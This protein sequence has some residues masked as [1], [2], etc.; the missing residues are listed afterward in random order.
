[1]GPTRVQYQFKLLVTVWTTMNREKSQLL[2]SHQF[3]KRGELLKLPPA[4]CGSIGW[5]HARGARLPSARPRGSTLLA[6]SSVSVG[7]SRLFWMTLRRV[8]SL[9][10][11]RT[12]YKSDNNQTIKNFQKKQL[13]G[14]SDAFQVFG[15]VSSFVDNISYCDSLYY[16]K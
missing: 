12:T 7:G 16:F 9:R 5:S 14:G 1:M 2:T 11:Y 4:S 8:E 10:E 13:T 3:F 6:K 15:M